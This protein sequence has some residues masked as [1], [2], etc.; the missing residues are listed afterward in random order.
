MPISRSDAG[1]S[2]GRR[3]EEDPM[4]MGNR[5][6]LG[7]L[8]LLVALEGAVALAWE[9]DLSGSVWTIEKA[10]ER[11]VERGDYFV[12]EGIVERKRSKRFFIVN[13]DTG[14]MIVYIP[15]YMTREKGTPELNE[16]I[17]V[18]GRYD[19]KRLDPKTKGI[20]AMDLVRLGK[21]QGYSGKEVMGQSG[22][23]AT[24]SPA[25]IAGGQGSS[26]ASDHVLS[27]GEMIEP[28]VGPEWLER[29]GG[30]RQQLL[31]ARYEY[32][33]V[34]VEYARALHTAGTPDK[35]DPALAKR[36]RAAE[37][38]YEARQKAIPPLVEQARKAGV[39]DQTLRLYE[40][41]NRAN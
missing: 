6:L 14:E 13:D 38:R 34:S 30:A 25:A 20:V 41:L 4:A 9:D 23:S 1:V 26:G 10:L 35:V 27:P 32:E 33:E 16:R 37:D 5:F 18:G 12:I 7:V 15:E 24:E 28:S 2:G 36:Y 21:G 3:G 29:L 40:K 17:R 31:E 39:S 19:Q 8:A 22:R 11:G